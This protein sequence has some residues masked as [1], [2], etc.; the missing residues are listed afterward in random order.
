MM[1]TAITM[2]SLDR[3]ACSLSGKSVLPHVMAALPAMLSHVDCK[4]R[5]A[6]LLDI[7]AIDEG[8][9]KQMAAMLE[10]ITVGVLNF[11]RD[12][13]PRVRYAAC[14]AI[15]QMCKDFAPNFEKKFHEQVVTGLIALLDDVQN[16]RV[17]A[18]VGAALVNFP[19]IF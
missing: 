18:Q 6:A 5:Y 14:N 7:S 11:L 1:I 12:P 2:S 13:H 15:G 8:C 16:S 19:S 4:Q 17:Q 3:L 9:H 10:Q